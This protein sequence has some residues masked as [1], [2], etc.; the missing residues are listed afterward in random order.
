MPAW[1]YTFYI[2]H[3]RIYSGGTPPLHFS[4]PTPPIPG[5]A[6]FSALQG[7]QG[8]PA[9]KQLSIK[10]HIL[11]HFRCNE[12]MRVSGVLKVYVDT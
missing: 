12:A 8:L 3:P 11:G 1:A 4:D 2:P 6:G 9:D 5:K 7:F 10:V